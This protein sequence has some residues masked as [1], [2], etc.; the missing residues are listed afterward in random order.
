MSEELI[1]VEDEGAVRTLTLN[2][3]DKLN[4]LNTS[5]TQA[6]LDA[7]QEAEATSVRA[8]VLAGGGRSFCAG[9]DLSEFGDLTPDNEEA[10]TARAE[11]TARTQ[12]VARTLSI[13]VIVAVQGSAVGGGAGLALGGDLLIVAED[14]QLGF[15][16]LRHSIV[17]A[18][19]MAGLREHFGTKVAFELVASG[20][21]VGAEELRDRGVANAVVSASDV[22]KVAREHA[23]QLAQ[24]SRAA[25]GAAKKLFYEV[26][27]L[28]FE[29]ALH[30]GRRVNEQMRGFRDAS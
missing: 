29:Q 30:A 1:L 8:V 18:I 14:A 17:P 3:P 12:M 28:P 15:P 9:A 20:R 21:F 23:E 10:V 2:R 24:A 5:L 25:V 11:L 4:A 16:E 6:L 19:V 26:R 27:D 13:P 22:G 7:F